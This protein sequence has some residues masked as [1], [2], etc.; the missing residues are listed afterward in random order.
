MNDQPKKK[1]SWL[2]RI[3]I[4]LGVLAGVIILAVIGLILYLDPIVKS[5]IEKGAPAALGC[6]A[7]VGKISVRPLR[8]QILIQD[9][10]LG[11]PE[12]YKEEE[13]FAIKEFRVKINVA[14]VLGKETEPI[15]INEIIIHSPKIAYEV[16]N[17]KANFEKVMERFPKSD[18]PDKPKDDKKP[19]R[20]IIIDH[21]EFLDGQVNVR[22]PYTFNHTIP[23][24]LPSV[25]INDIGRQN[26]GITA[27]QAVSAILA[28]LASTVTEL[29]TGSMKQLEEEAAKILKSA[30]DVG[31][32]ARDAG[33][34]VIDAGKDAV[35]A[36]K[37]A[38]KGL[39]ELF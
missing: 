11:S 21:V 30:G 38:V 1:S 19:A 5:A 36:T 28:Q 16:V 15:V 35:D 3:L 22:A 10:K 4:G 39:K 9:L 20:K 25:E 29:V 23:L 18:K 6:K 33:K 27:V 24:P 8:G 2:K 37:D 12:G 26:N 32:A 13:M 17:G 34:N 14:S 7:T 31:K